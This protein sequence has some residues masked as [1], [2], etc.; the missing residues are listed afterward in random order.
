MDGE[1]KQEE[2]FNMVEL[3][4]AIGIVESHCNTL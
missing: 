4:L 2:E 3:M 1:T